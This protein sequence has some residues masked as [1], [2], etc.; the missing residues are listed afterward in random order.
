M[1]ARGVQLDVVV[2]G[3][4][5]ARRDRSLPGGTLENG[6]PHG[7]HSVQAEKPMCECKELIRMR[8]EGVPP[9]TAYARF[10][11]GDEVGPRASVTG[12]NRGSGPPSGE[13]MGLP[14]RPT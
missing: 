6:V 14:T 5:P 13:R 7:R 8:K 1:L 12:S 2:V 11:H 10:V 9:R 3:A 4:R